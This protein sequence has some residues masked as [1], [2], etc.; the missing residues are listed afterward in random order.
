MFISL[1]ALRES[2]EHRIGMSLSDRKREIRH[3]AE[4]SIAKLAARVSD[5][6]SVTSLTSD[7][8]LHR[9][10]LSRNTLCTGCCEKAGHDISKGRHGMLT[11]LDDQY[12]GQWEPV[13]LVSGTQDRGRILFHVHSDYF[14]ESRYGVQIGAA[15]WELFC[16]THGIQ[17]DGQ[18]RSDTT[19]GGGDVAFCTFLSLTCADDLRHGAHMACCMLFADYVTKDINAALPTIMSK[20]TIQ[21]VDC[22]P[23]GFKVPDQASNQVNERFPARR[24]CIK[25]TC[26]GN[27]FFANSIADSPRVIDTG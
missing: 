19:I 25:E 18:Q 26:R 6:E 1:R 24:A 22:C 15:C 4:M 5:S 20:R 13:P 11:K 16:L 17:F 9:D 7:V 21:Y 14:D 8:H 10:R 23:I 27:Q 2:L 12:A 3:F